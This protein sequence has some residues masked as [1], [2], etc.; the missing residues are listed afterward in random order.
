[1]C[2]ETLQRV[3]VLLARFAFQACAFNHSAISPSL[4][5]TNYQRSDADYRTRWRRRRARGDRVSIQQLAG[6]RS[7]SPLELCQTVKSCQT[8]Y[9]VS[10]L[11]P[12]GLPLPAMFS[13]SHEALQFFK[14]VLHNGDAPRRTGS[15]R[16]TTFLQHQ[17]S[18][19]VG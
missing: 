9:S 11:P 12:G 2:V 16:Q 13:A 15:V 6:E 17:E 7:A 3:S 5:S 10:A 4:E 8:T 1:M 18:L 19:A 14:P